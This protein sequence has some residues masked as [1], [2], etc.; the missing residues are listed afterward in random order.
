MKM[1][2]SGAG[3]QV[4]SAEPLPTLFILSSNNV[5]DPESG[6]KSFEKAEIRK[7]LIGPFP[8]MTFA[9]TF[10]LPAVSPAG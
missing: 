2:W 8:G 1:N 5:P 3:A 6:A 7:V 9:E 10:Q 4:N